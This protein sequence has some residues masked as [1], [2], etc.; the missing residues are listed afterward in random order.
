MAR[1]DQQH[2]QPPDC[3]VPLS[4]AVGQALQTTFV[5]ASV[6]LEAS[7]FIGNA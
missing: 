2:V 4:R 6:P 7:A 5:I 3:T 1:P